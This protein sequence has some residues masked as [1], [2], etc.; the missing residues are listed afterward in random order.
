MFYQIYKIV[1]NTKKY[2]I[3]DKQGNNVL[4][5]IFDH[6]IIFSKHFAL[7]SNGEVSVVTHD[8][9]E[10]FMCNYN[11]IIEFKSSYLV[12]QDYLFGIINKM[13]EIQVDII[14]DKIVETL[15]EKT[16]IVYTNEKAGILKD[17]GYLLEPKYDKVIETKNG[18]FF[19]YTNDKAGLFDFNNELLIEPSFDNIS[20]FDSEGYAI[21]SANNNYGFINTKGEWIIF[22]IYSKV[23]EFDENN[24]SV[25]RSGYY[26]GIID[27]KGRFVIKPIYNY[28]KN[29]DGNYLVSKDGDKFLLDKDGNTIDQ[30]IDSFDE[31][32]FDVNSLCVTNVNGLFGLKDKQENIIVQPT[33]NYISH[34]S[35]DLYMFFDSNKLGLIDSLGNVVLTPIYSANSWLIYN[36]SLISLMSANSYYIFKF[37]N[38]ELIKLDCESIGQFDE[39]GLAI[40]EGKFNYYGLV[41]TR[42]EWVASPVYEDI[43][44]RDSNGYYKAFIAGRYGWINEFGDWVIQPIFETFNHSSNKS[45]GSSVFHDENTNS[46]VD[47]IKYLFSDDN[48]FEYTY[49]NIPDDL[50]LESGLE[51][52]FLFNLKH[53]LFVDDSYDL[54]CSSGVLLS[55]K[56]ESLFLILMEKWSSIVVINLNSKYQDENLISITYDIEK[57]TLFTYFSNNY[58]L[59]NCNRRV[60]LAENSSDDFKMES[61]YAH[62]FFNQNSIPKLVELVKEIISS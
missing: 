52:D 9:K 2:G 62:T 7:R 26:H 25:V 15:D 46:I 17:G 27:R 47:R 20:L 18:V 61:I 38:H 44:K 21:A 12:E 30:I 31:K 32:E 53:L 41:N 57:C 19:T 23:A 35:R 48:D 4:D 34:L 43:G 13:G 22:P 1:D 59:K 50:K 39:A 56:G 3:I 16:F 51:L 55:T 33:Y 10:V 24:L 49:G 58:N 60:T 8:L 6:I 54:S 40:A 5:A 14:Y 45:D 11:S 42:G 37:D 28:C 29:K 36:D